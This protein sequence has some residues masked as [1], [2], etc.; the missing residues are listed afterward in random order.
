LTTMLLAALIGLSC[1][2]WWL[3]LFD[4]ACLGHLQGCT[5][6]LSCTWSI[7]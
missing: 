3:L 4:L 6:L 1:H 2:S 7:L 5:R